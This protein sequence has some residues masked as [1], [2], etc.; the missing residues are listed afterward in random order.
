MRSSNPHQLKALQAGLASASRGRQQVVSELF[1]LGHDGRHSLSAPP[2]RRPRAP[3]TVRELVR[4][5]CTIALHA[6]TEQQQ[7]TTLTHFAQLTRSNRA[8]KA[9]H[10]RWVSAA[11]SSFAPPTLHKCNIASSVGRH[12]V[13]CPCHGQRRT[14]LAP[15]IHLSPPRGQGY[16]Q[17][18]GSPVPTGTPTLCW[19]R[20]RCPSPPT[21]NRARVSTGAVHLMTASRGGRPPRIRGTHIGGPNTH[22]S[23]FPQGVSKRKR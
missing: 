9:R 3:V 15:L 8:G 23:S 2:S 13:R 20:R 11:H 12:L 16:G 5:S 18:F 19:R 6:V 17:K 21:R 4:S 1:G 22:P 7:N 14:G 10:S